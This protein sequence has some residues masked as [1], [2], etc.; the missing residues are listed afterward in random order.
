M[1]LFFAILIPLF[2]LLLLCNRHR[3]KKIICKVRDMC[4]QEKYRLIDQLLEPFGY[5]YIAAQDLFASRRDAWQRWKGYCQ[6]YDDAAPHLH[7]VFD[8]LPV[9]FDYRGH[10]WL[11]E[12]W[13]GQYG[14]N[15]GAE[16]GLYR[17]RRVLSEKE[18][19][20]ALF[21]AVPEEA[22]LRMSFTLF[23][24]YTPVAC[25]N[26]VHWWL[27]AFRLGEFSQPCD[28]TLCASVDF[29]NAEMSR[30]FV[31][32]LRRAGYD[33]CDICCRCNT[34]TISFDG[35]TPECGGAGDRE[36]SCT[37]TANGQSSS[38]GGGCCKHSSGS[39]SIFAR[40]QRRWAQFS[41]RFWCRIYLRLTKPF[42]M[43]VDKVLYLYFYLPFAFRRLLRIRRFRGDK[44]AIRSGSGKGK[45]GPRG[46]NCTACSCSPE[47][48]CPSENDWPPENDCSSGHGCP[49]GNGCSFGHDCPSE[50]GCSS[51]NNCPKEDR[52]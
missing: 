7:M 30:A 5:C 34:V 46:G 2:L 32:G 19:K 35:S 9:Y 18:Y 15:T 51:P 8:S 23:R 1:Y 20:T 10:T 39:D 44:K 22:M 16:I 49:S 40:L 24:N 33:P 28:L 12:F 47:S 36:R 26:E 21:E 38:H 25:R 45:G 14:I 48:D 43:S 50:N 17:A 52:P 11:L 42:C 31:R 41:N 3:K 13:K 37:D 6:L 4:K 27:T 29:P